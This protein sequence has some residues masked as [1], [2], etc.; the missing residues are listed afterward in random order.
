MD[1]LLFTVGIGVD[2]VKKLKRCKAKAE[3]QY[4]R[5]Q[6]WWLEDNFVSYGFQLIAGFLDNLEPQTYFSYFATALK[7][8]HGFRFRPFV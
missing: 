3:S 1:T 4:V 8:E 2:H 7:I 6:R 5:L